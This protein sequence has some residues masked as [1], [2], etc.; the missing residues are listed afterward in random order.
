MD[1]AFKYSYSGTCIDIRLVSA[2]GET[3]IC[4]SNTGDPMSESDAKNAATRGWRGKKA[5]G[6]VGEGSGIGLWVVDAIAKAHKGRLELA[7]SVLNKNLVILWFRVSG[8]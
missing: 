3:G 6:F 8:L 5:K 7:A 1:N 4:I 2:N